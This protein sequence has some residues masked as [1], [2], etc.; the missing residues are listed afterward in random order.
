MSFLTLTATKN[1]ETL[2]RL[3]GSVPS[4]GIYLHPFADYTLPF[5]YEG[6]EFDLV[7][8]EVGVAVTFLIRRFEEDRNR[9][10][11]LP[12][13]I[14]VIPR[15]IATTVK[16]PLLPG[17]NRINVKSSLGDS[18]H[19]I[20][21]ADWA[22]WL[23]VT[24]D[25]TGDVNDRVDARLD[26]LLSPTGSFLVERWWKDNDLLPSPDGVR[27]LAFRSIADGLFRAATE[28]GVRKIGFAITGNSPLFNRIGKNGY[29]DPA[30]LHDYDVT[31]VYR[32]QEEF[33]GW[34]AHIWTSDLCVS[35]FIAAGKFI[36][37]L[38][39]M[40]HILSL[41]ESRIVYSPVLDDGSISD[42]V[43]TIQASSGDRNSAECNVENLALQGGCFDDL[44]PW[45]RM[46][47]EIAFYACYASWPL[48]YQVET[49]SALGAVYTGCTD[50]GRDLTDNLSDP[51]LV[52]EEDPTGDGWV[53]ISLV[54]NLSNYNGYSFAGL[55]QE[56]QD[57]LDPDCVFPDKIPTT[58]L[59]TT[60]TTI[61]LAVSTFELAGELLIEGGPFAPSTFPGIPTAT[62]GEAPATVYG[63][64]IVPV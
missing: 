10:R 54:R 52:D 5:T 45:V 24:G 4:A 43:I 1:T 19:T 34:D 14:T 12:N 21:V 33:S 38:R 22:T 63:P 61:T 49:C 27:R 37:N 62:G 23:S 35:S 8:S 53:G 7:V 42:E 39:S 46:H 18:T 47:A 6:S 13:K 11:R 2:Q 17:L 25:Q 64:I 15:D 51:D 30:V 16:L 50:H 31:R 55:A 41:S 57:L 44:R 20:A 26:T 29:D 58:P 36:E 9:I 40:Y 3:I 56:V 32:R 60:A 28:A 59:M 48:D